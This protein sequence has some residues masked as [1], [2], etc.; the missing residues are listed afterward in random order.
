MMRQKMP[1]SVCLPG[2]SPF[3]TKASIQARMSRQGITVTI[4]F[5]RLPSNPALTNWQVR[6]RRNIEHS[7]KKRI[8]P[9]TNRQ[10]QINILDG[11]GYEFEASAVSPNG[12]PCSVP[13]V[14]R[15]SKSIRFR[16]LS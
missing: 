9:I 13:Q 12:E 3:I 5:R 8:V 7:W 14:L 10:M 1:F 11:G 2:S 4:F 6:Y 15:I 16:S